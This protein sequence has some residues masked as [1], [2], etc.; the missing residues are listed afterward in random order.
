MLLEAGANANAVG[1]LF[2]DALQ[3][4]CA[5][6]HGAVVETLWDNGARPNEACGILGNAVRAARLGNCPAVSKFADHLE[7]S[8]KTLY[9]KRPLVRPSNNSPA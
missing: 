8:L 3:A 5:R 6:G 7:L 4:A 9:G 2:G 1:G